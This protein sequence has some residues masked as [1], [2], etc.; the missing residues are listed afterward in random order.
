MTAEPIT[1][2]PLYGPV[3]P[4]PGMK[5]VAFYADGSGCALFVHMDDGRYM[6]AKLEDL[7]EFS[8]D[9]LMDAGYH[10]WTRLPDRFEFFGED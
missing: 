7:G 10:L 3:L 9:A 6:D 2:Y 5:F 1:L 4:E 8:A